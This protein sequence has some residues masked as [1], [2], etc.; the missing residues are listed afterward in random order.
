[1]SSHEDRVGGSRLP[2]LQR[3]A[4]ALLVPPAGLVASVWLAAKR[5]VG[6]ALA[7]CATSFVG[8]FAWALF[9]QQ[10]VTAGP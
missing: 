5:D 2:G 4:L 10:F 7:V 1:M 3:Y 8:W 9:T 6:P